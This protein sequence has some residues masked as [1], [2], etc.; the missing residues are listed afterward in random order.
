MKY[1]ERIGI[2]DIRSFQ[3]ALDRFGLGDFIAAK[4]IPHGLFGQNVFL[5]STRGEYVFRGNPLYPGQFET[6]RYM[7]ERLH[8]VTPVPVPW[9][10]LVDESNE[11]FDW[12]Y[13][14]M[15]KLPG[16]QLANPE[17]RAKLSGHDRLEIAEA[18]GV[19][20]AH[21]HQLH[22]HFPGIYDP[23]TGVVRQMSEIYVPQ[24]EQS[25]DNWHDSDFTILSSEEIYQRWVFSRIGYFLQ[26]AVEANDA[27]GGRTT[28]PEDVEWVDG[29]LESSKAALLE[30]FNPCFVMNDYKEANTVAEKTKNRWQI[31]GVFDLM[32]AYFGDGEA[33]LARPNLD[34]WNDKEGYDT[35]VYVFL[36]AYFQNRK[37]SK[38][39]PGFHERFAVYTLMDRM[40]IWAYGRKF[41]WFD[42]FRDFRAWC[43]PQLILNPK[44]LSAVS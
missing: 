20:L 29:T 6:E 9:P 40:I 27:A 43:E 34:Y 42:G 16:L 12:P 19:N 37:D 17:I 3:Q 44:M 14:L 23:A 28:T 5:T 33:D 10:Y 22:H 31:T 24:W 4:A 15:P 11:I 7:A 2:I 21:M 13:V 35:R 38:T 36:N 32:E 41:G 26:T 30:P 18:L 25:S 39:R 1:S 8:A